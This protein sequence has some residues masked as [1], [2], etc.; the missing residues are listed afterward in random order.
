MIVADSRCSSQTST[1]T[2]SPLRVHSDRAF[3]RVRCA[4]QHGFQQEPSA[5]PQLLA[6]LGLHMP[7]KGPE[8]LIVSCR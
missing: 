2:A 7:R 6:V 3:Y 4:D 5:S 8:E 1:V